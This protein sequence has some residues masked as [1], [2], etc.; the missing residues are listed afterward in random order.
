[1]LSSMILLSARLGHVI[2]SCSRQ[3]R[4]SIEGFVVSYCAAV[5]GCVDG[6]L[7][8]PEMFETECRLH[9]HHGAPALR[10]MSAVAGWPLA[11][12]QNDPRTGDR[13]GGA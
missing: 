3:H 9:S 1:M 8:R 13:E 10:P 4:L 12:M 7:R 11:E 2:Q 6:I 5:V